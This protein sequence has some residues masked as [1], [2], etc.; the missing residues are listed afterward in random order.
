MS[1]SAPKTTGRR[2]RSRAWLRERP[3]VQAILPGGRADTQFAG[4]PLE[5]LGLP[6]HPTYSDN[7]PLLQA[8]PQCLGAA[9]AGDAALHQRAI[10]AAA[11]TLSIGDRIEIPAAGG[12]WP[13]EVIGIYADYGNPKGQ[14]TV[15]YAALTRRF[16]G[17]A[18]NPL[19]PARRAGKHPGAA[20]GDARKILAR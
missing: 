11:E 17:N 5:V 14:I 20:C 2:S 18:A 7:W 13:L 8:G 15:N 10:G 3:E 4:A 1:L 16:P 9:S 12:T 19:R 6:D